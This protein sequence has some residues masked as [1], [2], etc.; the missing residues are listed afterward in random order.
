MFIYVKTYCELYQPLI[1]FS[2]SLYHV[3]AKTPT[4]KCSKGKRELVRGQGC[5]RVCACGD[6]GSALG[7]LLQAPVI[8]LTE[9]RFFMGL[10]P[11]L[12]SV[13]LQL[14][15]EATESSFFFF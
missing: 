3:K 6:Q 7:V 11:S 10:N 1:P 13:G 15:T 9:T 4:Y 14:R 8:L 12:T 5:V 2:S